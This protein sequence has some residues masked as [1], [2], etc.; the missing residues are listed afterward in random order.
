MTT[1]DL[2]QCGNAPRGND[3]VQLIAGPRP[4]VE[5]TRLGDPIEELQGLTFVLGFAALAYPGCLQLLAAL[6][7][8]CNRPLSPAVTALAFL[9][10]TALL[11]GA[12]RSRL[13]RRPRL[14]AEMLLLLAGAAVLA[15]EASERFY[16]LSVD[17][18]FYQQEA[19]I[20]LAGGWNPF[21]EAS[22]A[23][24]EGPSVWLEHYAKGPWIVGAALY[25][26]AGR[27]ETAKCANGL[28]ILGTLCFV[29]HGLLRHGLALTLAAAT[30]SLAALNPV[31]VCQVVTFCVD[32]QMAAYLTIL[33]VLAALS[34]QEHD[35][36][37]DLALS[38]AVLC[39]VNVKLT[40]GLYAGIILAPVFLR[41]WLTRRARLAA[42]PAL[43][44]ATGAALGILVVGFSPYVTNALDHG[45]PAY[46][47]AGRDAVDFMTDSTPADIIPM[48]R[49]ARL[50][51][52]L[53]ARSENIA[54][55]HLTHRKWP[56]AVSSQEIRLFF[57]PD[58]RVAGFG[59]LFSG[60][61][62]LSLALGLALWWS[63]P[64][65]AVYA[66]CAA[67]TL[68]AS[69][70]V[71]EHGWWARY[72][73]QLWLIPLLLVVAAARANSLCAWL[74]RATLAAAAANALLVAGAHLSLQHE[75]SRHTRERLESLRSTA[76]VWVDFGAFASTRI[77]FA[78]AGLAYREV[79][80][81]DELPCHPPQR[82]DCLDCRLCPATEDARPGASEGRVR[83][84]RATTGSR[85]SY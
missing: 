45:H 78:E 62:V 64:G 48:N 24:P 32:G 15:A 84:G 76:P 81:V 70:L 66:S 2:A 30:A 27:I 61:L 14:L 37:V 68:L 43:A 63:R 73:P 79:H 10:A 42:R 74:R 65:A 47:L 12:F 57:I 60:V 58:A 35:L 80:G 6:G 46:P 82:I 23:S 20:Q 22:L 67:A 54:V 34:L 31:A 36:W 16:D 8:L 59:P 38:L 56:F 26:L 55:P 5:A 71:H 13:G 19:L 49:V 69:V 75:A 9:F 39:L 41:L 50:A 53:F 11:C 29:L 33:T 28:L 25:Q 21:Y 85:T 44:A 18:Q 72:V 52:S 77:R 83:I 4:R 7:F 17:G 3:P 1:T 40:G 51:T